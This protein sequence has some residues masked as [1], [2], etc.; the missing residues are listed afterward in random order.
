M[1]LVADT[2]YIIVPYLVNVRILVLKNGW[3]EIISCNKLP[4]TFTL[5]N[6]PPT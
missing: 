6:E 4:Y 2:A 3:I 1:G 5:S